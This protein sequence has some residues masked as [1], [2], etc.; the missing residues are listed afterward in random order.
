M[1]ACEAIY[2]MR[3]SLKVQALIEEAT[4]SPCP[5]V[6]GLACPLLSARVRLVPKLC[7]ERGLRP[8][9]DKVQASRPVSI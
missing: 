2:D 9:S 6:G 4:G 3:T 1:R 8:A 5:C 7:I